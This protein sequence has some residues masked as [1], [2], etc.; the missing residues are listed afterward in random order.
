M[1]IRNPIP[2]KNQAAF[3]DHDDARLQ[4]M[5]HRLTIGLEQARRG[6]LAAG[7]GEAAIRRAF[8][9]AWGPASPPGP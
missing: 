6:E 7:S 1:V 5:R 9:V 2:A 8:V 3:V 4:H